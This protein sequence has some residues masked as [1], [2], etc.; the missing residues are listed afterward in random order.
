M[1]EWLILHY[2][3]LIEAHKEFYGG[4]EPRARRYD[5]YMES[6]NWEEWS[7][8]TVSIAEIEKLFHFVHSWDRFFQGDVKKLQMIYKEIRPI[9]KELENEKIE[10]VNFKDEELEKKIRNL[11]DKVA[12]C[13]LINRYESTDASKILHTILPNFF[14]MW[15]NSIKFWVVESGKNGETYAFFFLPKVQEELGEAI[16][17][18]MEEQEFTRKQAIEYTCE[19]CDNKTLAKLVD[20]YNLMKYTKR[21][22][23]LWAPDE[24]EKIIEKFF[25]GKI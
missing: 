14:V 22:R 5:E 7:S 12:D 6:K 13:T 9:I 24:I 16:R 21:Y 8:N 17:S 11:F 20:E 23:P 19:K 2:K 10:D 15:D 25:A 4:G 18:C 3:K 1:E